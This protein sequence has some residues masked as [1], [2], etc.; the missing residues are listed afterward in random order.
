MVHI[1]IDWIKARG[2]L[3]LNQDCFG[4][5]AQNPLEKALNRGKKVVELKV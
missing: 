1:K 2:D 3:F 4:G 5:V